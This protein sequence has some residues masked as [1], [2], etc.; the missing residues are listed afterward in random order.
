MNKNYSLLDLNQIAKDIVKN[1]KHKILLFH[2][3]MGVGKTTLIKEI[4]KELGTDD[5]TSSPTFSIVNQYKTS[6]NDPI[7]H[8]DFYRVNNEE[9][10]YNIG[11]E[12]YFYTDA[13][14]LIEWPS[15]I[16]NLLPL[17][18]SNIYL[19]KLDDEQRNIQLK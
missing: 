7:Y 4:C 10:A 17:I 15:I 14:C 8:F 1:S 11:V 16:K 19:T 18:A 12:D 3:E 2:G 6:N 5:I 13:W 9:E